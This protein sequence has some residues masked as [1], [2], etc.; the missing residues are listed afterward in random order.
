MKYIKF[1]TLTIKNFLSVGDDPVVINFETGINVITGTNKDKDDRRNGVGKS[2][3]ADAVYFTIFGN[4]LRD[5][6]KENVTR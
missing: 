3:V 6:K 5:I 2:T 1:E 4:T